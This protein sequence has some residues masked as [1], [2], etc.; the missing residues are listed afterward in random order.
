MPDLRLEDTIA[1]VAT[2]PGEGGIA[3]LRVSGPEALRVTGEVFRP[4]K[5]C[6]KDFPSHTI[7]LGE[8]HEDGKIID[9][10]LVSLFRAPNSYTGEEVVEI[11]SHGGLLVTRKILNALISRGARHAQPGEF[12]KRAFLNG[13]INL[14]QAE[15]VLDLIKAKSDKSLE[16]AL[17][18]LSGSLSEKIKSLKDRLMKIYAHLEAFLDFPEEDLEI[19]SDR[20]FLESFSAAEKELQALAESFRRGAIFR[21]G[22]RVAIVGRPNA[23]KSSL[24]NVL[25]S[26]DR[27][28]VS[29]YPGTTR[30]ILEEAVEIG[31]IYVRLT[32]TAGLDSGLEHPLDRMGMERT[33]ESL[34]G[35]DYYLYVVD[36]S[37]P[38]NSEEKKLTDEIISKPFLAVL[39]K[40]DLGLKIKK[41]ISENFPGTEFIPVSTKTR[42][43]LDKLE[44]KISEMILKSDS[45]S[46]HE[47]L[48]RLRHK[49][50]V[51]QALD[52]LRRARNNFQNRQSL[53]YPVE[54]IKASL[55]SL[56]ELIGEVY[57]EDLLDV[58][59]S[60]FCIGK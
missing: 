22:V 11:S 38:W 25:L 26:R 30:D 44:E 34:K 49:N 2:P 10:A 8:I 12:T 28:L 57:S 14:T 54:D 18:Q 20:Q 40:C 42:E 17:R 1:A 33:R 19:Y 58:I 53:E 13:K 31:G 36:A 45:G 39:N 41:E 59:F 29:E 32:D 50:A 4:Q 27:A 35:A 5:G 16:T 9:Q 55:A 6:L 15:A 47:H 56:Q 7:H 21:E 48:T 52:F 51:D 43:G 24:F 3:V 60:E 37:S 23:G 46:E